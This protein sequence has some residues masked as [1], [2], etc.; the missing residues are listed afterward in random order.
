MGLGA[1]WFPHHFLPW[2]GS[3]AL[4]VA[5]RYP[6]QSALPSRPGAGQPLLAPF[7]PSKSVVCPEGMLALGGW[8]ALVLAEGDSRGQMDMG[9]VP[10][11]Q[12]P[13]RAALS[14]A[15]P[16][17]RATESW[18]CPKGFPSAER[19]GTGHRHRQALWNSA[20]THLR[21]HTRMHGHGQAQAG[22]RRCLCGHPGG[23]PRPLGAETGAPHT[24]PSPQHTHPL[25]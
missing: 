4:Q 10:G 19:L 11:A 23:D 15:W 8:G 16:R 14:G 12:E 5:L 17:W 1:E 20:Q 7:L 25:V 21:T 3:Q 24:A 9:A 6:T 22:Q 18:D 13:Q 2:V